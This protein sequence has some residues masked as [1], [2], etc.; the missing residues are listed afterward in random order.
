MQICRNGW[1]VDACINLQSQAKIWISVMIQKKLLELRNKYL[2]KKVVSE[3]R[4]ESVHD[5]E[6]G[7]SA[8]DSLGLLQ[9]GRAGVLLP[10]SRDEEQ[11]FVDD[12]LSRLQNRDFPLCRFREMMKTRSKFA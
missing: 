9:L 5:S 3:S 10:L 7:S 2:L 8:S 12:M 6:E 4:S 11:Q 1:Q